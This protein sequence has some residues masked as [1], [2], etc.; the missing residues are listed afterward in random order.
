[1]PLHHEVVEKVV[2]KTCIDNIVTKIFEIVNVL[3]CLV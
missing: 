3:L 1:M 2:R